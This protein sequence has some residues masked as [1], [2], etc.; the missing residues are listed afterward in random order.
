[1]DDEI[2]ALIL[3]LSIDDTYGLSFG[4][5]DL[6]IGARLQREKMQ[7]YLS[8]K[9]GSK[10]LSSAS[11]WQLPWSLR[12]GTRYNFGGSE[13][14]SGTPRRS[15][16]LHGTPRHST[17]RH[18]PQNLQHEWPLDEAVLAI[19]DDSDQST[20][21]TRDSMREVEMWQE[22]SICRK[23]PRIF[24]GVTFPC[25]DHSCPR[26][27]NRRFKTVCGSKS[28][29]PPQCCKQEIHQEEKTSKV[30]FIPKQ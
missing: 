29:F 20:R 6:D 4:A 19:H 17:A 30:F 22:S 2:F 7:D 16:A 24:D 13:R 8:K 18:R 27:L 12:L 15:T 21:T 5:S 23:K 14:S 25:G 1:M 3:Q 28:T 11:V 26:C 10:V 9:G